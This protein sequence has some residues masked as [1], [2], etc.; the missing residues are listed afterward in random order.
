MEGRIHVYF[1]FQLKNCTFW[2]CSRP[3]GEA[4]VAPGYLVRLQAGLKGVH[5]KSS[6]QRSAFALGP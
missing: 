6:W 4:L 2:E 5:A 1:H 3:E